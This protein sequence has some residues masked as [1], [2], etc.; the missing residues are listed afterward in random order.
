MEGLDEVPAGGTSGADSEGEVFDGKE[1]FIL[2]GQS[3]M[4]GMSPMPSDPWPINERVTFMV[5]FDCDRLGQ[6]AGGWLPA[7]PPLH[8]CQWA[9]GGIGLGLADFFGAKM[10]EQ[11]PNSQIGLVPNAVP[12]QLISIYLKEGGTQAPV[13]PYE[14]AYEMTVERSRR[15]Q[16][17]GRIRAILL[18]QGESDDNQ[19][20]SE[21]WLNR[22]ASV[23]ADLRADLNLGEAVPLLAGQIGPSQWQ[24][25]NTYV[26]QVPDYV[27][28]S[29]VISAEGTAIHDIAHF[30][31]AS[32]KIMGERYVEKFLEMVP[33]P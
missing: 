9:T 11:W 5:Q 19:M 3:N 12:G 33:Q 24:K 23:V 27:P 16:E 25:H 29:A 28:N 18:H 7:E 1:L 20:M 30:D 8:G 17:Q 32:A 4:S 22:V 10:A 31:A 13:A 2:I 26:D 6:T 15:A 21:Q 14:N